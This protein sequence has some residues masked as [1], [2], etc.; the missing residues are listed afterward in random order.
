VK[1]KT[2]K[3]QK[4]LSKIS[5]GLGNGKFLEVTAY[6]HLIIAKGKLIMTATDTAIYVHVTVDID[7]EGQ[8]ELIVEGSKLVELVDKTTTEFVEFNIH[9]RYL[10]L[11]SNGVYKLDLYQGE[12][13]SYN[14]SAEI[15]T[16]IDL[17]EFKKAIDKTTPAVAKDMTIPYLAGFYI[18][19]SVV[20]TDGIKMSVY[21][22]KFIEEPILMPYELIDKLQV[23][24]GETATLSY[25]STSLL[26]ET[27]DTKLYSSQL[28]GID[29]FP[30]IQD[31]VEVGLENSAIV[32]KEKLI[33]LFDRAEI[34][35]EELNDYAIV[36]GYEYEDNKLIVKSLQEKSVEDLPGIIKGANLYHNFNVKYI[37]E[38][39]DVLDKEEINI[40]YSK[41]VSFIRLQADK[42][43]QLLAT[44]SLEEE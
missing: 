9:E 15:E 44:V 7:Y 11:K 24:E 23:L 34:F 43:T 35:T 33:E 17:E 8:E 6:I 2:K 18:G 31:M 25:N 4:A 14:F 19:E 30:E 10:E 39:L 27:K 40:K 26:F 32:K 13:P 5:K 36:L 21:D 41:E 1:I 22:N 29:E 16:D 28:G 38:M 12:F 3:L 37:K 42:L 20:T